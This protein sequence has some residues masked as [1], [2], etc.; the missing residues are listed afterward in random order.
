MTQSSSSHGN[1]NCIFYGLINTHDGGADKWEI[2][3]ELKIGFV[4]YL[5]I[6]TRPTTDRPCNLIHIAGDVVYRRCF[7]RAKWLNG[8]ARV[9]SIIS[10]TIHIIK[11]IIIIC[12]AVYFYIYRG[13]VHLRQ[14]GNYTPQNRTRTRPYPPTC[15]QCEHIAHATNTNN[16]DHHFSVETIFQWLLCLAAN[17]YYYYYGRMKAIW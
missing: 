1:Q 2:N 3:W 13:S 15:E 4:I 11:Q 10:K 7:A 16:D 17:S 12:T 5:Y 9:E 8:C 14:S 6:E